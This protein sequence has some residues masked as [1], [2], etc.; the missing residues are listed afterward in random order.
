MCVYVRN[1]WQ[2]SEIRIE[3]V[4]TQQTPLALA[5]TNYFII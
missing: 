3:I 5:T 2:T 1:T 4:V